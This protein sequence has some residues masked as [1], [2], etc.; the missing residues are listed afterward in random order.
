MQIVQYH[1]ALYQ[2]PDH[3]AAKWSHWQGTIVEGRGRLG[4][5]QTQAPAVREQE[6]DG[7]LPRGEGSAVGRAPTMQ[8]ALTLFLPS[9][10]STLRGP[11]RPCREG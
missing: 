9:L 2:A 3:L 5:D 10:R 8:A 6:D 1:I 7:N 11:S 4:Q